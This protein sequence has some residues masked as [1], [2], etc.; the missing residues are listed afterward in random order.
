VRLASISVVPSTKSD[1]PFVPPP[2]QPQAPPDKT[3]TEK[4]PPEPQHTTA[5]A[6]GLLI[7]YFAGIGFSVDGQSYLLPSLGQEKI[8]SKDAGQ[9]LGLSLDSLRQRVAACADATVLI[10]DTSFSAL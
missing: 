6:N 1:P 10:M 4:T 7:L 5:R 2:E 3:P 9:R 8:E